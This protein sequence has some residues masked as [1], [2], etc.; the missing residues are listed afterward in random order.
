MNTSIVRN[1]L[2]LVLIFFSFSTKS[3]NPENYFDSQYTDAIQFCT[4]NINLIENTLSE[5]CIPPAM[6]ISIAFP[7]MLRY[8]LWRD[9]FE[10]TSLELL[11]VH[12]G[13]EVANFS[14]GWLQMKPSFAETIEKKIQNNAKYSFK[15]NSLIQYDKADSISVRRERISR[16]KQF[17][18]QLQYLS[19]FIDINC[20]KFRLENIQY[21][22]MLKYLAAAYNRGMDSDINEL[23]NFS[24]TKTFPYGPGKNNPF[25]FVEVAEYFFKADAKQLFNNP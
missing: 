25:G 3:N 22:Q 7:E 23:A 2:I 19:A 13:K 15:Y 1:L 9:L 24:N 10:T 5:C 17:E 12:G 14:I 8:S 4:E 6:A 21:E 11:Y 18:W 20:T 16:L